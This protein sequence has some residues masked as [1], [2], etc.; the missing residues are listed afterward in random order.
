MQ[1]ASLL[2]NVVVIQATLPSLSELQ[3]GTF[4]ILRPPQED[5]TGCGLNT[6][7]EFLVKTPEGAVNQKE[8]VLEFFGG[9]GCWNYDTCNATGEGFLGA[10][11]TRYWLSQTG[12]EFLRTLIGTGYTNCRLPRIGGLWDFCHQDH[13]F[14]SREANRLFNGLVVFG[15]V[16]CGILHSGERM[17]NGVHLAMGDPS[18]LQGPCQHVV[19]LRSWTWV[20][21]A[22]CTG[23]QHMGNRVATYDDG[24]GSLQMQI[25]C[26]TGAC[27]V[28]MKLRGP[29]GA[30]NMGSHSAQA[31]LIH[32]FPDLW[33][34]DWHVT[35]HVP[36]P[37]V[38]LSCLGP[39]V[40]SRRMIS[41]VHEMEQ[42][43]PPALLRSYV[44]N[45]SAHGMHRSEEL[46]TLEY[47]GAQS[48]S[49]H[50]DRLS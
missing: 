7:Y 1:L 18:I 21:V 36:V 12:L 8:L 13:P 25:N 23:D 15:N 26:F 17:G 14:R 4:H 29:T 24:N 33:G 6:P 35:E 45:G 22:Y 27:L 5:G 10:E 37:F 30:G 50:V 41:L 40:T 20:T 48:E 9:G 39:A 43:L 16:G 3:A 11:T 49:W 32:W 44:V 28:V 46:W 19:P 47:E 42:R 2:L 34:F 38:K 31:W